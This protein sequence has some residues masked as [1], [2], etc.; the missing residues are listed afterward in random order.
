MT[1]AAMSKVDDWQEKNRLTS[2]MG[3]ARDEGYS[4]FGGY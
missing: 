2:A 1:V 4:G 3:E